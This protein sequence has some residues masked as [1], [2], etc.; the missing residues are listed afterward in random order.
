MAVSRLHNRGRLAQTLAR[1]VSFIFFEAYRF[2]IYVENIFPS[3]SMSFNVIGGGFGCPGVL[4]VYVEPFYLFL[5]GVC[6]HKP[7]KAFGGI[8]FRASS[9]K[10]KKSLIVRVTC[11]LY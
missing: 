8:I 5:C 11:L 3:C 10:K 9:P 6:P 4:G 1:D 7:R 2:V